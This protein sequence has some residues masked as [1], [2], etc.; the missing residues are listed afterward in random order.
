MRNRYAVE[1]EDGYIEKR[2]MHGILISESRRFGTSCKMSGKAIEYLQ[3]DS[4][5]AFIRRDCELFVVRSQESAHSRVKRLRE[6]PAMSRLTRRDYE[7]FVV[8]SLNAC[9]PFSAHE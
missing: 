4:Q 2:L 1:S 5:G 7:L 9:T 6:C 3:F 8:R